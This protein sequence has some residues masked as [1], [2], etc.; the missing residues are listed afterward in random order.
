MIKKKKTLFKRSL[1]TNVGS[2]STEYPLPA[3]IVFAVAI[4]SPGTQTLS[5]TDKRKVSHHQH[6]K[7]NIFIS[8]FG[9]FNFVPFK[10]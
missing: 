1:Q 10:V 7:S 6:Q 4:K 8:V 3:S 2:I 9:V 5:V